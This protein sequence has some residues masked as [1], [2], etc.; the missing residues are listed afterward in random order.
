[1]GEKSKY[2]KPQC[3]KFLW[4]RARVHSLFS[5]SSLVSPRYQSIRR[6][7]TNDRPEEHANTVDG[8]GE[9]TDLHPSN[10]GRS[11]VDYCKRKLLNIC[12]LAK[13]RGRLTCFLS[14]RNWLIVFVTT[15]LLL[16]AMVHPD[17]AYS[18]CILKNCVC[19]PAS[20]FSH[21]RKLSKWLNK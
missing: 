4:T 14:S 13:V 7:M 3:L 21:F 19:D 10:A 12:C 6:T 9:E 20:L 17:R 11:K 1:M 15:V 16:Q 18:F 5:K 2:I 8:A